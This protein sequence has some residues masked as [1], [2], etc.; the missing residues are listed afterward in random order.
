[1]AEDVRL[2]RRSLALIPTKTRRR[3]YVAVALQVFVNLLD[4]AGVLLFGILGLML[5]ALAQGQPT[6]PLVAGVADAVGLGG[7]TEGQLAVTAAVAAVIFLL[8]KTALSL[9]IIRRVVGF[10]ARSAAGVSESLSS[11]FLSM[12]LIKVQE[13]PSQWSAHALGNGVAVAVVNV[14]TLTM[15]II[16]DGSL[17]LLFAVALTVIEPVTTL[18][19]IVY[20]AIAVLILNRSLGGWARRTGR[21]TAET[22]VASTTTIQDAIGTYRETAVTGRRDFYKRKFG[23]LRRDAAK[24][25]ADQHFILQLPRYVLESVVVLGVILLGGLLLITQPIEAVVGTIALYLAAT[26]RVLP[27]L[28]RLNSSRLGLRNYAG[29]AERAHQLADF[30]DASESEIPSRDVESI[31]ATR[32]D[33]PGESGAQRAPAV[34]VAHLSVRYP[35]AERPALA[36]VSFVVPSG[37]SLA[38]VGPSGSG[39]TTLI[40]AVLGVIT[41]DRGTVLV[42]GLAPLDLVASGHYAVAYVPQDVALVS[43]SVRDNV[44]LA[45]EAV[46]ID[47]D[48]VWHALSA[49]HLADFLREHRDGLDT[50]VGERAVRLSG[51]QRQRLGIARALYCQPRILVMDE[52]TSALDAETEAAISDVLASLEG[53]VTTITVAHRLATV[54]QSDQVA[55]LEEGRLVAIGTFDDVRHRVPRFDRQAELL[56]L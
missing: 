28:V 41:P 31:A 11:R 20:L 22:T 38:V 6:P 24:A 13:N 49:A 35:G 19:V 27:A 30:I 46:D 26:S 8:T 36:D 39:K 45:L 52:A 15:L 43:G 48:A 23:T 40:D 9:L 12:P 5:G 53:N 21:I 7:R 55:Y 51:G 37:S 34:A 42:E 56:G 32:L 4:L 29:T 10:L 2:V 3:Y 50:V 1:M 25:I 14:L 54:R 33:S 18:A 47:D 16:A 44:A 17:L